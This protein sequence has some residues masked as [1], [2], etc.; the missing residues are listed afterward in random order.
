MPDYHINDKWILNRI[1]DTSK[2]FDKWRLYVGNSF[3]ST[4]I[5]LENIELNQSKKKK[6][7][8]IAS[9]EITI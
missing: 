9:K 7:K 6:E 4:S 8:V 5:H 1:S 3:S 2:T